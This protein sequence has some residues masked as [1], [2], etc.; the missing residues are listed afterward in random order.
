MM[1]N[2]RKAAGEITAC[3]APYGRYVSH[4]THFS[5]RQFQVGVAE[6]IMH[7]IQHH[8]VLA[9][10]ANSFPYG[11]ACVGTPWGG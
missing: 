10:P 9:Q 1:K 6:I 2:D 8:M 4:V 3:G 7:P 5:G 11:A